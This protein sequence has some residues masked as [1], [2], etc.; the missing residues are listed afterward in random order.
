MRIGL[1][2]MGGDFAPDS[3]IRGAIMALEDLHSSDRIVLFGPE[4]VI[5]EKLVQNGADPAA[6]DIVHA[7][8]VI[9]MG[10]KPIRAYAKKT[11][12][13]IA[14]GFKHL[15]N[16]QIDSFASAGNSGAMLVGAIYSANTIQ[17]VIRPCTSTL[18]PKEKGGYNVFLDIG[19]NPDIKPDVLYQFAIIGSIYAKYILNI[20]NPKV[21]LLNIGEEE[22]KGNLLCQSAYQLFSGSEDF[23]FAGNVE[24]RDLF[25]D[26]ADVIVCDGFTGNI[27]IKLIESLYRIMYKRN[28]VDDYFKR[29]NYENFGG[30]PVL[31]VNAAVVIGHG[32]SNDIAIRNML[33]LSIE[34]YRKKIHKI[35]KNDLS[36]H[37]FK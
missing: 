1:D 31:G 36:K 8:E 37:L 29:F 15:K 4:D 24:G 13:S 27:V 19:T 5:Q 32:I 7:P 3:S 6:F 20:E 11:N 21:G 12:S 26:K 28:L 34:I 2:V 25:K 23:N 16:K 9:G 33:N 14:M 10:E 30:S 17:G 22:E 18:I 35:I